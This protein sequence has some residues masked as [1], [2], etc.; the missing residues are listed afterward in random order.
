MGE[1]VAYRLASD[2]RTMATSQPSDTDQE[3]ESFAGLLLQHRG[4][5]GLTQRDVAARVGTSER[6]VQDWEAG[7]YYPG[8]QNLKSLIAVLLEAGGLTVGREMVDGKALWA[9]VLREAA[10][11]RTPFD[12]TWLA[13]LVAKRAARTDPTLL[14]EPTAIVPVVPLSQAGGV[15]HRQDWGEAPDVLRFIGRSDELATLRD[16]VQQRRCRLV[17]VR[18]AGG[19]GK[20]ILAARLAQDVAPTFQRVYWRSLRDAPPIGE[21]LAGA[22]AFVSDQRAVVPE[23]EGARL[24]ALLQLLRDGRNLLVLDNFETLLE[25]GMREGPYRDDCAGYGRLLQTIGEAS[26][27]SCLVVTSREAPPELAALPGDV[28]RTLELEGLGAIEAQAMLADKQLSGTAE[29]WTDLITRVGGNGLA[30]KL[31]GETIREVFAGDI[32]AFL[33]EPG[34]ITAFGGIRRLLSE[35]IERGSPLEKTMLRVLGLSRE[36]VTLGELIVDLG[37]S[38]GRGAVLEALEALRRR[39]LVERAETTDAAAFTLQSVVLEY[40]TD[41]LVEVAVS[42]IEH[43]RLDELVKWPIVR[44]EAKDFIRRTQEVLIAQAVLERLGAAPGR[45]IDA[46]EERLQALL[47]ELRART[48]EDQGNGPG[49]IANLLRLLRG[50][51]RGTDLSGL[52][53]RHLYLQE[54]EAQDASLARSTLAASVLDDSFGTVASIGLSHAAEYVAA[55]TLEGAVRVWR[56]ADRAVLLHARGHVGAVWAVALTSD[57][58]ALVTGGVDGA[59][60]IWDVQ[61]G[62]SIDLPKHGSGGI[63]SLALSRDDRLLVTGGFDS[64]VR[65]WSLSE[66]ALLATIEGQGGPAYGVALDASDECFAAGGHDGAVRVWDLRTTK[67]RNKIDAHEGPVWSLAMTAGGA[68]LASAGSDGLVKLWRADTG[69]LLATLEGHVGAV[70]SVSMSAEGRT[71]SSGGFDGTVRLWEVPGG[72]RIATLQGHSGGVRGIALTGDGSTVVSGGF[73]AA[74]RVWDAH[75]GSRLMTF[76]GHLG[77]V[78]GV[79]LDA[80]GRRVVASGPDATIRMW[81][82]ESG[83]LEVRLDGHTGGVRA[84]AVTPDMRM[85]ASSGLDGSV[86]LWD[87]QI[88]EPIGVLEG[89]TAGCL[90]V[91]LSQ[92]G[93]LV[94]SGSLDGTVRLWDSATR[95]PLRVMRGHDGAVWGVAMNATGSLIASCGLDRTIRVWYPEGSA[96]PVVLEGHVA[97]VRTV[98]LGHDGEVLVSGGDDRTVRVWHTSTGQLQ[99]TLEGHTAAVYGVALSADESIICSGGFDR[100]V[101]VWD[102]H[103]AGV[104]DVLEGH[105][106]AV[107]AVATDATGQRAVS[108]SLD[109]TIKLWGLRPDGVLQQTLHPDRRYERMDIRGLQGVTAAQRATLVALGAAE[110]AGNL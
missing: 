87:A 70:R 92:D 76:Q 59:L 46:V 53:I 75:T 94:A 37:P 55:G 40:V 82:V 81:D 89:H 73:D 105:T 44:A 68:T 72:R 88:G 83:H 6:S 30:L 90:A 24:P 66:Q 42:E 100:T 26:H 65:V 58:S 49:N 85:I 67:L 86:R 101:R 104:L 14:T 9:A 32:A 12:E 84:I 19:I 8:A 54:V 11:M 109:G 23:G 5:T 28:V 22:I 45:S 51:L 110:Q 35:Q 106:D 25:P 48:P 20:T 21:W 108:C 96:A 41:R 77:G 60:R 4:R 13:E 93:R 50:N 97:G 91:A 36:P 39:S 69:S 1:E 3:P 18:G 98:A 61:T 17:V 27:Q 38:V 99:A 2:R 56:T 79:G 43:G 71:V 57:G 7:V 78:R 80:A 15:D 62:Q 10:R 31:V 74:V 103:T 34:S 64:N 102:P 95:R 47:H 29:N 107:Y 63:A 16:S 52:S 33:D